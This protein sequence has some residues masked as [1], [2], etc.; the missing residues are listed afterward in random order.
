MKVVLGILMLL[1]PA[2]LRNFAA[3]IVETF[4][5]DKLFAD[6][7]RASREKSISEYYKLI[8]AKNEYRNKFNEEVRVQRIIRM[9]SLAQSSPPTA[10]LVEAGPRRYHR[11]RAGP[12]AIAT[13]VRVP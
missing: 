7:A 9:R 11:S 1:L 2:F 5:G 8:H 13:W 10:G 12:S 3:W 6:V 4:V